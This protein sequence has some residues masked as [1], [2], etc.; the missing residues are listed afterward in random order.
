MKLITSKDNPLYKELKQLAA[1]SQAR[2]RAGQTLLDGVHLAQAWLQHRGAP[3]LCVVAESAQRHPEVAPILA[4]CE[5]NR[6]QCLVLSD[7]LYGALSQVENGVGL[8]LLVATPHPEAPQALE[9]SAVLLDGLQ[10]PGNLGSVLRSAAAAG[11]GQVFC[12]AGTAAAWSPKVL[13]AGMG[14]HFLLN[15]YENADLERLCACSKIPVLATSS[16]AAQTIYQCDLAGAAAWLFGHEG[17]G[18]APQ[19][20]EMASQEVAIP[21]LGQMESLNVAAA[22]AVCFFEQVRQRQDRG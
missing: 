10:D 8:L 9:Q 13:R 1:S 3:Q 17:Q 19:L 5:R 18:V 16:H 7:N 22:A 4:E 20:M 11:I 21:H 14:A 6:T 2:R 12:S 15:I